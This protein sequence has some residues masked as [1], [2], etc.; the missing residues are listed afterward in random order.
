MSDQSSPAPLPEMKQV[1]ELTEQDLL[2]HPVWIGVHNYDYGQPWYNEADDQTFRPWAE[3]LPFAE[4]RGLA[5]VRGTFELADGSA[6]PGFFSAVRHNWDE[7]IPGRRLKDGTYAKPLQWSARRTG[8]PL[9]ILSLQNPV[10]F[11]GPRGFDFHLKRPPRRKPYIKDFYAAIGK[12]PNAVF[13][14]RF[15]ADPGLSTRIIVGQMDGFFTFPLDRPHEI[16]TGE[17]LLLEPDDPSA[18]TR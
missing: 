3:P 1:H 2:R 13:P 14:V 15:F 12:P 18:T 6:Y 7:P 10:I 8:G 17:T 16:D 11:I 4:E 9:T 5:L